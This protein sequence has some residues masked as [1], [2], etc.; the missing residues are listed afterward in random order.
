MDTQDQ[1]I[2]AQRTAESLYAYHWKHVRAEQFNNGEQKMMST[3]EDARNTV[4]IIKQYCSHYNDKH[5]NAL[6]IA[7]AFACLGGNTYSFSITFKSVVAYEKD[8]TRYQ[9]LVENVSEYPGQ[10]KNQSVTVKCQDCCAPGGIFDTFFDV[11][12]LDPPW[13]N[14]ATR[15][16]D[17]MV[18]EHASE[19]CEQIGTNK[20]AKY[21][22]LKL[23]T[24]AKDNHTHKFKQDLIRLQQNMSALWDDIQSHKI[25]RGKHRHAVYTI[26]CARRK[27]APA[28]HTPAAH[29]A[30]VAAL[31]T[32][33]H[34]CQFLHENSPR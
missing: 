9:G 2:V 5:T 26:V 12:F 21:V 33:L 3:D 24:R 22:F 11:I 28:A 20:T 4:M 6:T 8:E 27:V 31:L 10:H 32:Q 16:V 23:P 34:T 14:P 13:V 15:K 25:F 30:H 7:D 1:A 19:L 18:F 17:S 29:H